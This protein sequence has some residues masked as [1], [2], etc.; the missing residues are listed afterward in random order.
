MGRKSRANF[1]FS[2]NVRFE[3]QAQVMSAVQSL[4]RVCCTGGL[5]AG[6]DTESSMYQFGFG[7]A[8]VIQFGGSGSKVRKR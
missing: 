3:F 6:V 5:G 4:R 2:P 1:M 7:G 8:I